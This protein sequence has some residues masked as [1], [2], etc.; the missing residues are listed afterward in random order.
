MGRNKN[1]QAQA[2]AQAQANAQAQ[3]TQA[4]A[5]KVD[6]NTGDKVQSTSISANTINE[7]ALNKK[8]AINALDNEVRGFNANFKHLQ[9]LIDEKNPFIIQFFKDYFLNIDLITYDFLVN[10]LPTGRI[11]EK[12]DEDGKFTK[13][14]CKVTKSEKFAPVAVDKFEV[15]GIIYYKYIQSKFTSSEFLTM[16]AT[17]K[18]EQMKKQKEELKKQIEMSKNLDQNKKITGFANC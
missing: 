17:A 4:Q 5:Q 3:T 14:I 7:K 1:T 10:N 18:R 2:Q 13:L 11:Y 12:K 6:N 16:F 15:N 8:S 9:K